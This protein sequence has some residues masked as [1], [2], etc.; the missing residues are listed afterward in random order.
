MVPLISESLMRCCRPPVGTE[1]LLPPRLHR[2]LGSVPR[3]SRP[4]LRPP[5]QIP[6]VV[7]AIAIEV[8]VES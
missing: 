3:P 1:R 6:I 5:P 2:P 8:Y 7:T 4:L